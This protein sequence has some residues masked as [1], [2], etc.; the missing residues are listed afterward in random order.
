MGKKGT[1]QKEKRTSPKD[2][3]VVYKALFL[4]VKKP[5]SRVKYKDPDRW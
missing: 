2:F 5:L 1:S 4:N 3:D